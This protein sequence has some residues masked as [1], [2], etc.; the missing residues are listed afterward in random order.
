M[1]EQ[2]L[3]ERVAAKVVILSEGGILALHPSEI[4]ANRKWHMP[5]GIREDIREPIEQ[6]G[7]REVAEETG[8]DISG[9]SGEVIKAGEWPAIDKGEHV[10]ILAVF[11]L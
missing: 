1:N 2:H 11:Y 4:D 3:A 10:R 5:G 7:A 8:I 6:T 9:L